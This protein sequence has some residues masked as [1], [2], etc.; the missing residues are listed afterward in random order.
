M[1]T[2]ARVALAISIVML[3]SGLAMNRISYLVRLLMAGK[4][5]PGRLGNAPAKIKAQ[6]TKVIGQRKLL[7]WT[8]PGVAHAFTFWGFLIV[9]ITLIESFGEIFSPHFAIPGPGRWDA[10]GF[11]QDFFISLVVLSLITFAIIRTVHSPKREGRK[12][13]FFGGHLW[14]AYLILVMI[15]G[16]V[17]TVEMVRGARW[18]LHTLPYPDGAFLAHAIG[19]G[20]Q[21]WS[22]HALRLWED[23]WLLGHFAVVFGFLVLV[24]NSKHLHIFTSPL[25]V[26]LGR[27]PIALGALQPLHIDMENMTEDTVLGVG[28]IEDFSWKQLLDTYTCTECGRCQS[29]CPAWNTGKELNPKLLIMN[30]RDH[31]FEKAPLLLGE[32]TAEDVPEIASRELVPEVIHDEVLWACVTCGACVYECPVD[33]EHVDAIVDMRR[34]QVMMESKFP[35][36]AGVMLRNLESSQN[37]WGASASQ[38]LDWTKGIEDYV[39]VVQDRIPPAAEYLYWVGCAGAFDDRAK[40]AVNAFARLM[41]EA[42]VGFAVLGP[43][44]SCT[45]DPARRIG[46]EYLFQEMAKSN[47]EMLNGKGVRKIV[48]SCPHCFNTM[49]NEY[50]QFGGTFEVIHHTQLLEKLIQEGRLTPSGEVA[51]KVTYHD[52]CYLARHN[53]ITEEPRHLLDAVPGLEKQEMHRCGK[54]T[55]CCGAGG[56]RMWMEETEGKR[57]NH[58]RI[59][60]A[61]STNPDMVATGCPYCMIMLDDA[62]KDRVQQGKASETLKV[63]DVS[64]VLAQSI[65]LRKTGPKQVAALSGE[66]AST[67]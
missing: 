24:V 27:Q 67:P 60:E 53:D 29:V 51:Q 30:M 11:I 48:A 35:A 57:I 65:A 5:A 61:L 41:I 17:S 52:P 63:F 28:K 2:T 23:G 32:T 7:Q 13:R 6:L 4:S 10:L 26:P 33:I 31:L 59:D 50:P 25:N 19:I 46:N 20:L 16:V 34:Y 54:K 56:A 44:E 55:F 58:E 18:A 38:R 64:Q 9:Q 40:K 22:H 62:V 39:V 43:Q 14:Q 1:S 66:S 12:S 21:H 49:A 42:G 8:V 45:G 3:A 47:I 37:P 36:E 15:F